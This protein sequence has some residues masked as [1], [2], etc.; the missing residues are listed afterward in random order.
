MSV[1]SILR[2]LLILA[3]CCA[4][5]FCSASSTFLHPRAA[6]NDE[7][8]WFENLVARVGSTADRVEILV[9]GQSVGGIGR[10]V[11]QCIALRSHGGL[12]T[13]AAG[14][15]LDGTA[16]VSCG[17]LHEALAYLNSIPQ[18]TS[19]VIFLGAGTFRLRHA[20]LPI[21]DRAV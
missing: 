19:V 2:R 10:R 13:T 17:G 16:I 1:F 4:T 20:P 18:S 5:S 9:A 7:G 3:T 14:L 15:P 12:E 11:D 8:T 21:V 6:L